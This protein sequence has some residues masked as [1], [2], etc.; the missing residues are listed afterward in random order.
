MATLG[1]GR[2]SAARLPTLRPL[3]AAAAPSASTHPLWSRHPTSPRQQRQQQQRHLA[4]LGAPAAPSCSTLP[5]RRSTA[6]AAAAD[7]DRDD[8]SLRLG[9]DSAAFDLSQQSVQSWTLFFGLLAGVSALV[10]FAWVAPG[11]GVGGDFVAAIE[12]AASSSEATM[13]GILL[14]F[15]VVH[16]GMAFLRPY[17]TWVGACAAPMGL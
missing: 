8:A 15:A 7:D 17:G 16:S 11:V 5:K 14:V 9:E 13:V 6:L 1:G 10:Y 4:G 3:A 12:G 2:P